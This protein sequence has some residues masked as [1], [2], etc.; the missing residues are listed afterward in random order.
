MPVTPLIEPELVTLRLAREASG[1]NDIVRVRYWLGYDLD[2]IMRWMGS[3]GWSYHEAK[4]VLWDNGFEI[5]R[6]TI[7]VNLDQGQD[8]FGIPNLS[9]GTI[10]WLYEALERS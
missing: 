1:Y 5:G 6:S 10:N 2:A 9:E 8:D 4:D 3:E 7:L